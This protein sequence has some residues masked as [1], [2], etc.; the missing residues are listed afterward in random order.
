VLASWSDIEGWLK[1]TIPG[2]LVLTVAGGLVTLMVVKVLQRIWRALNLW[3]RIEK[4]VLAG[5]RSVA[6]SRL[7]TR[8]YIKR[9]DYFKFIAHSMTAIVGFIFSSLVLCLMVVLI[10]VYFI[11]WGLVFSSA[12]LLLLSLFGFLVILWVKDA[13][14]LYG[15][16]EQTFQKDYIET[17]RLLRNLSEQD[18][19]DLATEDLDDFFKR[20]EKEVTDSGEK[21][22][23]GPAQKDERPSSA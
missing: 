23:I 11:V 15:I 3:S 14:Y 17:E 18:L 20:P 2:L 22:L 13:F 16:A 5:V 10:G 12:L 9:R 19:T 8:R 7:L 21:R 1:G 4:V 6:L